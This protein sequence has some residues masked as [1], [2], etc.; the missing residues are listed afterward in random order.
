MSVSPDISP[1]AA[2]MAEPTR[3]ALLVSLLDGRARPAGEL[4]AS[5]GVSAQAASNHL[6]R[7]LVSGLV[8]VRPLGRQR[9]YRLAR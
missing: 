2:V 8:S 7:L 4:A 3:A 5:A 9:Q 1:V 6:G